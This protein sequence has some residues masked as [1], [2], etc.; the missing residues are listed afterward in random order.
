MAYRSEDYK[1][2]ITSEYSR[3]GIRLEGMFGSLGDTGNQCKI[4]EVGFRAE[5]QPTATG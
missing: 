1:L 5:T 4:T 3:F 2:P